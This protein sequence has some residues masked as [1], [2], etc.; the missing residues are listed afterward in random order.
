MAEVEKE[1]RVTDPTLWPA[2]EGG[3]Y[4]VESWRKVSSPRP[5]IIRPRHLRETTW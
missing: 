4:R 5:V 2:T 3:R 1:K